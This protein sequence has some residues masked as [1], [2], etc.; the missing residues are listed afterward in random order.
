M[1]T[2]TT[3]TILVA[4]GLVV[5]SAAFTRASAQQIECS[6]AVRNV[7]AVTNPAGHVITT[8]YRFDTPNLQPLLATT[9]ESGDGCL[10]AH[11]SGQVRITDN[12]VAF[13]VRV[14][15]PPWKGSGHCHCSRR[16]SSSW[17]LISAR[18][19][20]MNSSSTPMIEFFARRHADSRRQS[21][22]AVVLAAVLATGI[23][24][25]SALV[26]AYDTRLDEAMAALQKAAALVEASSAGN[27]SA[28]TQHT[29]DRHL[30][31]AL[32]SIQ[33]AM[34]DI[35]AAGLAADAD[36]GAH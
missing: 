18:R 9:I 3:R 1:S 26:R 6:S 33:D 22:P 31:K 12:Y 34:D 35:V 32:A 21:I 8:R 14:D 29:F 25:G 11:L 20:M 2:L 10:I 13:Q 5:L 16:L 30:G 23:C 15:G 19:T 28:Q 4:T 24:L 36:G 7:G 17:Q 27:V